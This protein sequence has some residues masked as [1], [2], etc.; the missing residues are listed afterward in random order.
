M[1]AVATALWHFSVVPI[2]IKKLRGAGDVHLYPS[3]LTGV[4]VLQSRLS[5]LGHNFN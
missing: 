1:T 5:I 2:N 4:G 3:A